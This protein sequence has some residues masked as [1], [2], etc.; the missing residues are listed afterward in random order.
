MPTEGTLAPGDFQCQVRLGKSACLARVPRQNFEETASRLPVGWLRDRP[1]A[2]KDGVWQLGVTKDMTSSP[3][4][5]HQKVGGL[6]EVTT[7]VP[8]IPVRMT[9]EHGCRYAHANPEALPHKLDRV[10]QVRVVGNDER[11]LVLVVERVEE[12][13]RGEI[14]VRPFFSWRLARGSEK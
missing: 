6:P 4:D 1:T 13:I 3:A 12:Q 7:R 2:V 9:I 5:R 8:S 11:H 10:G 14:D